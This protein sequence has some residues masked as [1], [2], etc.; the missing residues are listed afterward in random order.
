LTA[1]G[2]AVRSDGL[3]RLPQLATQNSQLA[4]ADDLAH[5]R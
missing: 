1:T 4:R 2:E 3:D 5:I